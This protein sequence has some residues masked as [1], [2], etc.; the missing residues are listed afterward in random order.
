MLA[1]IA[2]KLAAAVLLLFAITAVAYSLIN[3]GGADVARAILGELAT[4]EQVDA[5]NAQ[6]GLDR[7]FLVQ[8]TTWLGA[9][10]TGNFGR[11]WFTAQPVTNAI[12]SRM[13]VTLSLVTVAISFCTLISVTLGTL[14]A[15][16]R[17]WWDRVVQVVAVVGEALPN[18]WIGLVLV[19]TFAISIRIFPA[20]G[21]VPLTTSPIGWISTITLPVTA[22]VVGSV[23]AASSQVRGALIDV[24]N[25]D[26]IRTLR[27]RGLPE[28]SIILRHALRNA[29]PAAITVLS[30]Q[31]IGMIGGAVI[32]ERVFALP[33]LGSLAVESTIRGDIPMIMGILVTMAILVVTVNLLVDLANAWINPK[34]RLQ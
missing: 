14:A 26:Y 6:L 2:R 18:F 11:S 25:R 33:G 10:L 22:L 29:A 27:A 4:Q 23:A 31:F 30:L 21:F 28:R 9:V 3:L 13:G 19:S 34:A 1:F 12:V 7:P 24:L 32:I 5:L 16:R 8:Y 17:G 20:T 15:V